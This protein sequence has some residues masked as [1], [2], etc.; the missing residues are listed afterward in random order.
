MDN[1]IKTINEINDEYDGIDRLVMDATNGKTVRVY[2][3]EEYINL[4]ESE[5]IL[6]RLDKALELDT[7]KGNYFEF[8]ENGYEVEAMINE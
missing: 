8:P 4:M 1:L 3:E 7:F 6:E 5:T 2:A